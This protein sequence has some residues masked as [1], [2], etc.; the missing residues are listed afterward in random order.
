MNSLT[1]AGNRQSSLFPMPSRGLCQHFHGG[2]CLSGVYS[3]T[4]KIEKQFIYFFLTDF[5]GFFINFGPGCGILGTPQNS[6]ALLWAVRLPKGSG[7]APPVVESVP[8]YFLRCNAAGI[9]VNEKAPLGYSGAGAVF[10]PSPSHQ[11]DPPA[12]DLVLS[13]RQSLQDSSPV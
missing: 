13:T 9:E 2:L 11:K 1:R 3:L 6:N 4:V 5:Q 12:R 7:S 10:K 8:F